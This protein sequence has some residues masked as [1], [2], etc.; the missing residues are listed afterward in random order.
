MSDQELLPCPMCGSEPYPLEGAIQCSQCDV[1]L[2]N[3]VLT[4]DDL[5]ECWN[6]R[7]IT[8]T[9]LERLIDI[10]EEYIKEFHNTLAEQYGGFEHVPKYQAIQKIHDDDMDFIAGLRGK[11]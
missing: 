2:D 4:Y 10:A 11:K 8:P 6:T 5:V 1:Q 3:Y 9:D 7:I